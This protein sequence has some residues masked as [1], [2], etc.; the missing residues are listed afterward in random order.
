[1]FA[2]EGGREQLLDARVDVA[3]ERFDRQVGARDEQLCPP[4]EAGRADRRALGELVERAAVGRDQHVSGRGA[5]G[6]AGDDQLRRPVGRHVLHRVDRRV[7]LA[8]EHLLVEAADERAGFAQPV[9]ELVAHLIAG[10]LDGD[11]FDRQPATA[12]LFLDEAGLP[13]RERRPAGR[14]SQPIHAVAA[15]HYPTLRGPQ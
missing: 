14:E 9:D 7:E 1:V 3:A 12:E 2:L 4:A 5:L 6:D 8:V 13:E 11:Q 10:R 15:T